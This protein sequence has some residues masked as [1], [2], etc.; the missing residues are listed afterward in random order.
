MLNKM[1]LFGRSLL[2]GLFALFLMVAG[3]AA[4]KAQPASSSSPSAKFDSTWVDYDVTESGQ[5]GMRIHNKFTVYGM[6]NL[7]SY[8][9]IYFETSD[10]TRLRDKNKKIY[11][12]T[13]EVAI[14]KE[15]S[16][17]YDPGVFNDVSVFMPYDEL[18]LPGGK[19]NLRMDIDLIY[20]AGGLIQHMN[21]HAF[22]FTQPDATTPT[23]SQEAQVNKVWIDYDITQ[24]G[25]RGMMIHVDFKVYGLKG[26]DSYLAIYV[27]DEKGNR[28]KNSNSD[29]SSV[30]GELALFKSL[31]PG[32]EPTVY[33]DSKLFLPYDE[34]PVGNG[35]HNLKLDIDL[36]YQNG[37][38]FKHLDFKPFVFTRKR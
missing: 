8:L 36:I 25:R 4:V 27:S 10:G 19:Y 29:F 26:V 2:A 3:G 33:E 6:K 30:D 22:E 9:A 28:F 24:N 20:K 16:V 32:Y 15:L 38:L 18:D 17:G 35:E 23:S 11:S 13:G 1:N 14:Y 7:P 21:F 5:K 12:T 37:D 34:I 31:K